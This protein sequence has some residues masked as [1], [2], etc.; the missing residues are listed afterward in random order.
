MS[1]GTLPWVDL[2]VGTYISET[3]H[4]RYPIYTRGNAGEVWPEV[5]YPL[6]ISLSRTAGDEPISEAVLATG[7]MTRD[8]VGV[9]TTAFGGCYGGYMYIN[10]S[11]NRV[12]AVRTPGVTV[13]ENDATYLGSAGVAPPYVE[14]KGDKS[15]RASFAALR[16]GWRMLNTT[17]LPWLDHDL[18]LVKAWERRIPDLMS[19]SD[20]ELVAVAT[21]IIGPTMDL[22]S[23]HL[24]VTGQAGG[25]VQALAGLC[26]DRLGDR[27]LALTMLGGIGDVDSAAPSFALWELGRIAADTPSV[28]ALFDQGI[29]GLD[30]RLRSEPDATAFVE[31]FDDFLSRF[32]SRGPNEWESACEVWGTDPSMPLA[33][34]DRMRRADADHDPSIRAD[35]LA[36]EREQAIADA[37]DRLNRIQRW[38]FDKMLRSATLYSQSRERSKTTIVRLIHVARLLTRELGSRCAAR[39]EGGDMKDIWFMTAEELGPYVANPAAYAGVVAERRAARDELSRRV[40]PFVFEGTL[41]DPSTWPLRDE[42]DALEP[43]SVGAEM[44]GLAGCAGVAEGRARVVTDPSDPGDIGP[45]DVL[46]APLTDPAWTPLFVPVEAVVVDVGGQMSHAVIVSRELGRPCVV[47]ATDASRRIPDG[48]RIRVDGT[49][50]TVTVLELP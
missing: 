7:L 44:T 12:L 29:D 46:V 4:E 35:R 50:G 28:A 22:F 5:A 26:E 13:D 20:E 14:R 40:P 21:E 37:R 11:M 10:L 39:V 8:E 30:E 1:D 24:E 19:A 47:A 23:R 9:G 36:E 48:A 17:E 33:F 27:S 43:L 16:Y 41:P 6:T 49:T 3:P 42:I 18:E 38:V 15:L 32:G 45:G 25:S 2:G 34:V 31:A